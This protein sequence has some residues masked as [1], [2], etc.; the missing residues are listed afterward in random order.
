MAR[1]PSLAG[2]VFHI[3]I[4]FLSVLILNSAPGVNFYLEYRIGKKSERVGNEN[5]WCL[6]FFR[7]IFVSYSQN[8]S[9]ASLFSWAVLQDRELFKTDLA[10]FLSEA[11]LFGASHNT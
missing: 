10:F 7:F 9:D 3:L 8:K 5:G 1:D 4:F 2:Q 11:I 6:A